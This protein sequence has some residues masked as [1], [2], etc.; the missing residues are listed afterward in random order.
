MGRSTE[1][2]SFRHP[3]TSLMSSVYAFPLSGINEAQCGLAY[4]FLFL[5]VSMP[6]DGCHC[7]SPLLIPR[8]CLESTVCPL[9]AWLFS[10]VVSQTS[11]HMCTI[12]INYIH[13]HCI[14]INKIKL[15]SIRINSHNSLFFF[16]K[17]DLIAVLFF[18][19][20]NIYLLC[21]I[22]TCFREHV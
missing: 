7:F 1:E 3:R 11:L 14:I 15:I 18:F 2:S 20:V 19:F 8:V 17:V 13:I 21:V 6:T 10:L 9:R 16:Y 5:G 4:W 22:G 12:F